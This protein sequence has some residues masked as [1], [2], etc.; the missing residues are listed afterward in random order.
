MACG[1][2]LLKRQ[3]LLILFAAQLAAQAVPDFQRDVRPILAGHCFK[4]HGPDEKTRKAD[5]RL[6]VRPEE[7]AFTR[8]AKRIDHPD[9]DELM[10]P[11]SAKKP[12]SAAQK[13]VLQKWV[14][15]GAGYTE[16]WAFIPPKAKPLPRVNQTDWPRND[17]DHFVLA[18]LEGAGKP[19]STEAD[20]YRLIR[21]LSLDLIGLPPTPGEVREFV[22]DT[23]PDA[24]ERL[25][26]RLLDR[27]EYGEHWASSWLDL[28]R[29]GCV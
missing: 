23:R 14:Q 24:Y 17:I 20:R 13:K 11:P 3:W 1:R 6:D 2:A 7:D 22:E 4:C 25:V 5:L 18:R 12:L 9:L 8:L 10:P 26:D 28:A 29:L 21:R 27:P 19:P 15:A 16:H